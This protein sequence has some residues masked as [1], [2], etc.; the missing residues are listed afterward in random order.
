M[1]QVLGSGSFGCVRLCRD[2]TDGELYAVKC[3]SKR[4]MQRKGGLG[5]SPRGAPII[6][7]DALAD[8][9]RE[10]AILKKIEHK[11]IVRLFEVMDDPH[12]DT[13]YMVFEL[14][15]LGPVMDITS[16]GEHA[17]PL[18]EDRARLYFGQ[19]LLAVEYL[20]YHHIVHRDI[21]PANLLLYSHSSI[22]LADFGVSCMFEDSDA[23]LTRTVGTP[24]FLPPEAINVTGQGF[25]GRAAD[26]WAMGVTLFCFLFARTPWAGPAIP[27]LYRNIRGSEPDIPST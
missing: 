2:E 23:L 17:A 25:G 5:R 13:V 6:G 22:R 26:V 21:K 27:E 12:H 10:I 16:R 15:Q 19:L 11:H 24:A 1:F 9:R 14:M 7:C 18:G 3:I 20:H 8:L 4:R